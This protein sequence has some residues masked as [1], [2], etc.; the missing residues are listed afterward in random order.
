MDYQ[1]VL[2]Q[3]NKYSLLTA[4]KGPVLYWTGNKETSTVK[5]NKE[6]IDMIFAGTEGAISIN[7]T[8]PH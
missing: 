7:P 1:E 6:N 8:I 4:M 5:M 3:G 2:I